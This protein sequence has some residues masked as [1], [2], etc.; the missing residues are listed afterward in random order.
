MARSHRLGQKN[1]VIVLR[2]ITTA[3]VEERV[4]STATTKLSHEQMVIQ[5]GMFHTKYS[6][7]ASRA[8]ATEAM[9]KERRL[10]ETGDD[11]E[12]LW[13]DDFIS[14]TL[15]RS[16]AELELFQQMDAAAKRSESSGASRAMPEGRMPKWCWDWC[17]YGSNAQSSEQG[18]VPFNDKLLDAARA[19]VAKANGIDLAP[20]GA[21]RQRSAAIVDV[22]SDDDSGDVLAE[23]SGVNDAVMD[24]EEERPLNYDELELEEEK[25]LAKQQAMGNRLPSYAMAASPAA[26]PAAASPATASAFPPRSPAPIRTA[27]TPVLAV[28]SP[29]SSP[30]LSPPVAAVVVSTPVPS[31]DGGKKKSSKKTSGQAKRKREEEPVYAAMPVSAQPAYADA[32]AAIPAA[33]PAPAAKKS[34]KKAGEGSTAKRASSKKKST[35]TPVASPTMAMAIDDDVDDYVPLSYSDVDDD[36]GQAAPASSSTPIVATTSSG[37]ALK[38]VFK[39]SAASSTGGEANKFTLSFK[40]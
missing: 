15:A 21:T 35:V 22:E 28:A 27:A 36:D 25:A 33:T 32:Y 20:S 37:T 6:H 24:D 23:A 13:S 17:L 40:R 10:E 9:A 1:Q 31:A 8:I 11:E 34:R 7:N 26:S 29:L 38:L 19:K 16:D 30:L 12:D 39:A 3:T 14:R 18:L 4:L 5:A 2:F